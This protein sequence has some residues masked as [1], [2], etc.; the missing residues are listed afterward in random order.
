MPSFSHKGCMSGRTKGDCHEK[1]LPLAPRSNGS[2][3]DPKV[4]KTTDLF[5]RKAPFQHLVQKIVHDMSRKSDLHMQST[6][7]LALQE[8][9]EYLCLQLYQLVS[10]ARQACHHQGQGSGSS[11]LHARDQNEKSLGN[12]NK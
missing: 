11:L 7:L 1:A 9:A 2:K 12:V 8:A 6:A 3:G 10:P 5:I 4:P